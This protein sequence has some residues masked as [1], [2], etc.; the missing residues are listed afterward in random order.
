VKECEDCGDKVKRRQR[1]ARCKKM[2][3]GWCRNHV[4]NHAV[5]GELDQQRISRILG[6]TM[7]TVQG[8]PL[9]HYMRG[10]G[11]TP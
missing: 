8:S 4:H 10:K 2:V 1:C 5:Q 9:A 6:S 11:A 7:T 3:C